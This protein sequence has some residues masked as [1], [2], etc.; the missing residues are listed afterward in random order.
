MPVQNPEEIF[1]APWQNPPDDLG[2]PG[3]ITFSVTPEIMA[4]LERVAGFTPDM[5]K[6][7][8]S[9]GVPQIT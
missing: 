6:L 7:F 9:Y 8:E 1:F 5:S 4:E 2:I 3:G